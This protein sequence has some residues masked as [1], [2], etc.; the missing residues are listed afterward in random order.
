MSL[1]LSFSKDALEYADKIDPKIVLID[2][3]R[4]GELMIDFNIGA[5]PV[6]SFEIKR[7]D[8]DYFTET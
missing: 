6:K 4:L 5:S 1:T 3:D 2:G 8:S 7:V